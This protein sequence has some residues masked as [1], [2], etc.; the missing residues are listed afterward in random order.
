MKAD[1][2]RLLPL[3]RVCRVV[4]AREQVAPTSDGSSP[5]LR[6]ISAGASRSLL[7]FALALWLVA[8]AFVALAQA[9]APYEMLDSGFPAEDFWPT[10]WV[11]ND[12]VLFTGV[13]LG[14]YRCPFTEPGC[15]G[16]GLRNAAYVWIVSENR[17]IKYK[18]RILVD[19]CMQQGFVSYKARDK[20]EDA[21]A[22]IFAGRFGEESKLE[23]RGQYWFNPISCRYFT[24]PPVWA[25]R[26]ME[27]QF[28]Q[29]L[30]DQHGFIDY[31][32]SDLSKTT[33]QEI[34]AT[35]PV[36]WSADGKESH[37]IDVE[38]RYREVRPLR[39][40]YAPFA[41]EY[42]TR[43]ATVNSS[44]VV[45]A[46]YLSPTGRLRKVGVSRRVLG[47]EGITS[48]SVQEYSSCQRRATK[49]LTTRKRGR[50]SIHTATMVKV[51]TGILRQV[52]VSPDG[53]KAAFVYT[54]SQQAQSDGYKAWQQGKVANT[55]RMV[56]VC[57]R[58]APQ[59]ITTEH[60]SSRQTTA[61]GLRSGVPL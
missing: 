58:E 6:V 24:E 54:W 17:V 19:L 37:S 52:S 22:S 32:P 9:H 3:R 33:P 8:S 31:G 16:R 14:T 53:C 25:R 1:G 27:G 49:L 30:L 59:M 51:V 35:P 42:F 29:P 47:V 57:Q 34:R 5:M 46:F 61:C 11:D 40:A 12:R 21:R 4:M 48:R 55:I 20:P 41:N 15:G 2:R 28:I 38:P 23:I 13:E 60:E 44:A 10:A 39:F 26:R 43:A 56:D 18:D 7:R 36:F 50:L 45:P